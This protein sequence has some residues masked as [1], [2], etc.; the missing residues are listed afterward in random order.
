MPGF[1]LWKL[2]SFAMASSALCFVKRHKYSSDFVLWKFHSFAIASS[3]LCFFKHHKYSSHTVVHNLSSFC[4]SFQSFIRFRIVADY[5]HIIS[6]CKNVNLLCLQNFTVNFS[7][8][9]Q[10]MPWDSLSLVVNKKQDIIMLLVQIR[11]ESVPL[12]DNLW[13]QKDNISFLFVSWFA[14]E[15]SASKYSC[16]K[17]LFFLKREKVCSSSWKKDSCGALTATAAC[18]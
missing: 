5:L 12:D 6:E 7:S 16:Q 13:I 14:D 2:H 11:E 17:Q 15:S 1:E 10:I 3:S 18:A 8:S 4:N 9:I